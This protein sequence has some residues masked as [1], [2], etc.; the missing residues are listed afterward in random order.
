MHNWLFLK[1]WT[2]FYNYLLYT[3]ISFRVL[4]INGIDIYTCLILTLRVAMPITCV[5]G[6]LNNSE[7]MIA[8][9]NWPMLAERF[10]VI[11]E[12]SCPRL[13]E[14]SPKFDR[15]SEESSLRAVGSWWWYAISPPMGINGSTI[16]RRFRLRETTL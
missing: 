5:T 7:S 1:T 13:C 2:I 4:T 15:R 3:R 14:Y 10:A 12:E 6:S 16:F 9:A 8:D 11:L